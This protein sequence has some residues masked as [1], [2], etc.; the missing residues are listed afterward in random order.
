M[1]RLLVI[2]GPTGSGKSALALECAARLGGEI[3]S[4]DAFAIYRGLDIGTAKPSKEERASIPHHMIDVADPQEDFSVSDFERLAIPAVEDILARGK[5]P[6][7]CGGTGFYMNA[8]LYKKSYGGAPSNAEIRRKYADLAAREGNAALHAR[9]AAVD[10]ESARILHPNDVKRIVRALE[11]YEQT[12]VKKSEQHD[13]ATPRYPFLAFLLDYPREE[14]YARIER[15]TARMIEDGL[16]G[17]VRALLN[18]G[19]PKSAQA[20]QAIGYKEVVE[21]LENGVNLSTMSDIITKNT[22]NYAKRQLTFFK[23]TEHLT[24]LMPQDAATAAEEVVRIWMQNN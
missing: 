24:R 18:R 10:P 20:M 23:N 15:R 7:L 17:E 13:D 12:G 8:V 22:R 6:V 14:L 4:C 3:V 19:V 5:I 11:I 9:L 16:V 21:F 2:C 1:N